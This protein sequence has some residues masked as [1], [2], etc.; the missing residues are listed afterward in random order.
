MSN[1]LPPIQLVDLQRQ[2]AG[3]RDEVMAAIDAA[4]SGMQLNLGPNVQAFER[5]FAAY[6][7]SAEG[8]GVGS[9]TDAL[10]LAVRACAIGAGD[11][12]ITVANTFIA[13]VEAIV[14]AGARPVFVDVDP[15]TQTLD[16]AQVT[17][18]ITPRTRAIMPVHLFG[19]SAAMAPLKALAAEHKLWLIED[20]SQ[21]QGAAY[22]GQLVGSIGDIGAF[23]LYFSKNLGGYGESGI[24]TTNNHEL[25]ERVRMLRNHG[26]NVRYYHDL[27]GMNSRLDEVQAAVLRIKLRRLDAWND[28]R[29]QHAAAYTERLRGLVETP[30]ERPG[31]HHV[32]YTYVIQTDE[33]DA[34]KD[35]LAAAGIASGI[36]YPLPLHLQA[37]CAEFAL[38]AGALP[39]SERLAGRILSLPMFPEL[40]E[41][42]IDRVCDVVRAH[43][44]IAVR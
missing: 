22:D 11:E 12:I 35:A 38:P 33:R 43:A 39:V 26:S 30:Y 19:Q 27:I 37:A 28:L 15:L 34:L 17:A 20:A 41:D 29:R 10:Y 8:I 14:M 40:R 5:E 31:S 44:R 24:V 13:T 25:A 21:A 36:H 7:G 1:T 2:Y 6:C 42:E 9:G 18:A 32:F 23:S 16:V 3:L 4:L